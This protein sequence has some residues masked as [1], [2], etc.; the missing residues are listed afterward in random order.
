[1]GEREREGEEGEKGGSGTS[2]DL[3]G[4]LQSW[5]QDIHGWRQIAATVVAHLQGDTEACELFGVDGGAVVVVDVVG[6]AAR[7]AVGAVV[8]GAAGSGSEVVERGVAV[9]AVAV[10]SSDTG[11]IAGDAAAA[12]AVEPAVGL[13][14]VVVDSERSSGPF[15]LQGLSRFGC[16]T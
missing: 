3:F 6:A 7:V 13:H 11:T 16:Q 5:H 14:T 10:E 15:R 2:E 4:Y 8:E 1:M 9:A 12:V